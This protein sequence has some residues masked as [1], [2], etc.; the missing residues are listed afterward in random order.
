MEIKLASIMTCP[1]CGYKKEES[2]PI[3]A[4]TYFYICENCSIKLSPK[5]GDCCVFCSY[6][7]TQCPPVQ[8][9]KNC[10]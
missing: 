3:N 5:D 7:S 8:A 4:C 1:N 6:G 9:S 2:M 10:C